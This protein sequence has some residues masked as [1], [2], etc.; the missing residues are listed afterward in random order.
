MIDKYLNMN[1]IFDVITNNERRG[2]MVKRSRGLDGRTIIHFNT[3]PFF[4]THESDIEFIDGTR[5]KY[6]VNLIADNKYTQVD[7]K[8]HQFQLIL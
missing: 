2:T 8:G 5:D 7:D 4:E 1:L 6:T 3:N